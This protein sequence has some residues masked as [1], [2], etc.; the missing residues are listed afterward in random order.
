MR[1]IWLESLQ[2]VDFETERLKAKIK[3]LNLR[4]TGDLG[5]ESIA[6]NK[7]KEVNK[8][9]TLLLLIMLILSFLT[10][11]RNELCKQVKELS[12]NKFSPSVSFT[13]SCDQPGDIEPSINRDMT[14]KAPATIRIRTANN[15]LG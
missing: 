2:P 6:S 13:Y 8:L 11:R 7:L 15:L 14:G 4:L 3:L 1:S 12:P 5:F 10:Q 9:S